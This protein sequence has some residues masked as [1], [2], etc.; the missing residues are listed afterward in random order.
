MMNGE[1]LGPV[2]L[3][4]YQARPGDDSHQPRP[5]AALQNFDLAHQAYLNGMRNFPG[6]A[7]LSSNQELLIRDRKTAE[8]L[9]KLRDLQKQ[10]TEQTKNARNQ[11]SQTNEA[12]AEQQS[13]RQKEAADTT[14]EARQKT[15]KLDDH[16][17]QLKA[18]N[19]T[20]PAENPEPQNPV[21]EAVRQLKMPPPPSRKH[22]NWRAERRM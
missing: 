11:Q 2:E 16:L 17:T 21:A 1:R 3:G 10:A 13:A 22:N 14:R 5:D 9:K 18:Q 7:G 15:K 4:D 6:D 8:Q 19:A 12:P 20:A